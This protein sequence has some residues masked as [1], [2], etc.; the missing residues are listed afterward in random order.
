MRRVVNLL[1]VELGRSPAGIVGKA[2][3][4]ATDEAQWPGRNVVPPKKRAGEHGE[5]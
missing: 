4:M 1:A 3:R 5:R 2:R